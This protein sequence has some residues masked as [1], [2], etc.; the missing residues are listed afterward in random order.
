LC[1]PQKFEDLIDFL[2]DKPTIPNPTIL[3]WQGAILSMFAKRPLLHLFKNAII[4]LGTKKE[5]RYKIKAITS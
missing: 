4:T 5:L 1:I 3:Q 2:G